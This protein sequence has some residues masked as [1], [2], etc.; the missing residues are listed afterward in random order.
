MLDPPVGDIRRLTQPAKYGLPVLD[1][2]GLVAD[3]THQG[4]EGVGVAPRGDG[5]CC[6]E[7]EEVKRRGCRRRGGYPY[8]GRGKVGSLE[9]RNVE[10]R[11]GVKGLRNSGTEPL[12]GSKESILGPSAEQVTDSWGP[13]SKLLKLTTSA[14]VS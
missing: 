12:R 11:V 4:L 6:D 8:S 9:R 3:G 2:A 5:L 13:T 1:G 10:P 14:A 7:P